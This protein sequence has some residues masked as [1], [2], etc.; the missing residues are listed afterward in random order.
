[1]LRACRDTP[2]L[3]GLDPDPP[4]LRDQS[5]V[6]SEAPGRDDG[7]LGLHIQIQ[8]GRENP[9]DSQQSCFP[10]CNGARHPGGFD[11]FGVGGQTPGRGELRTTRELLPRAP[12]QVGRDPDGAARGLAQIRA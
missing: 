9:I 8:Y 10:T 3:T 1:M 7:I 5:G 12:L 11:G 6:R 4:E 2:L